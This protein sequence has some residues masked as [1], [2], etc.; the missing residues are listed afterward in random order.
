MRRI[1]FL[2][3]LTLFSSFSTLLCCAL[4]SLMVVLGFGAVLSSLV[5]SLP[6]LIWIS[7]HKSVVFGVSSF[8]LLLNGIWLWRQRNTPCPIDPQQRRACLNAKNISRRI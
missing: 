5:S 2:D 3:H 1:G 7:E 6:I 8:I 4:P